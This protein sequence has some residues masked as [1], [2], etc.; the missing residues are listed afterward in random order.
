MYRKYLLKL[1][2]REEINKIEIEKNR[3]KSIKPRA[4]SLKE[5]TKLTHLWPG[6]PRRKEKELKYTKSEPMSA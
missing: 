4:D 2:I 3:K 1:K 5:K 6:S